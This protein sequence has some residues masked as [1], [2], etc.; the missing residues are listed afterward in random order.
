MKLKFI[1]RRWLGDV[2]CFL[3][4]YYAAYFAVGSEWAGVGAVVFVAAYGLWCF[5]DGLNSANGEAQR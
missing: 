2:V 4:A 3:I 1:F 5:K